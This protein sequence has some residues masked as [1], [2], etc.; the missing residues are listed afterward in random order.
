MPYR[1]R[2]PTYCGVCG[3]WLSGLWSHQRTKNHRVNMDAIKKRNAEAGIYFSCGKLSAAC[4][5]A[6]TSD[7]QA[8]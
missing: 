7:E 1:A 3:I 5:P 6:A 2:N 8:R 4:I